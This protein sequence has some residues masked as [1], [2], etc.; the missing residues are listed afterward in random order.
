[1]SAFDIER[2]NV[3]DWIGAFIGLEP[4][5][6]TD[7]AASS[8]AIAAIENLVLVQDNR[9]ALPPGGD[10]GNQVVEFGALH[11]REGV[12]NRVKLVHSQ[13][14]GFRLMRARAPHVNDVSPW[15]GRAVRK[16]G[17][18]SAGPWRSRRRS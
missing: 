8:I 1:M 16:L 9:L 5:L 11:Q 13:F 10:V 4:R 18:G 7:F 14:S 15:H 3:G 6:D 17:A 2:D 12:G